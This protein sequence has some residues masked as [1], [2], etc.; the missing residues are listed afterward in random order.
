MK[1]INHL[2]PAF[3]A[4][5]ALLQATGAQACVG[6]REPGSDTVVRESQTV[7]AGLAFSW[8]VLFMLGFVLLMVGGMSFYIWQ[9][10]R[11]LARENPGS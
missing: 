10:C 4:L 3:V 1:K 6:C 8:S 5:A 2:V 7:M 9:T 11:R